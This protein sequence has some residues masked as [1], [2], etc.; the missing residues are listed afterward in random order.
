MYE[1]K[2]I[3][4]YGTGKLKSWEGF[5]SRDTHLYWIPLSDNRYAEN[6]FS[7]PRFMPYKITD[8][9]PNPLIKKCALIITKRVIV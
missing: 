8:G 5:W 9:Y 2:T 7:W 6:I 4:L 1:D 3:R